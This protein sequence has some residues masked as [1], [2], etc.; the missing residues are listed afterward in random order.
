MR[1]LYYNL[2]VFRNNIIL[3]FLLLGNII[4]P[5][6]FN[7]KIIEYKKITDNY[8][9]YIILITISDEIEKKY[10]I[11]MITIGMSLYNKYKLMLNDD[12]DEILSELSDS[13][14]LSDL[15]D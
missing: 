6:Y 11:D 9:K 13:S 14:D 2:L 4:V 1:H 7:D 15:N 3:N 10:N 8:Y 5:K 12:N